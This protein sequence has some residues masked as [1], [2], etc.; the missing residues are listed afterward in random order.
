M[1]GHPARER[2]ALPALRKMARVEAEA[3]E[4]VAATTAFLT[5]KR[6]LRLTNRLITVTLDE[7]ELVAGDTIVITYSGVK[8]PATGGINTFAAQSSSYKGEA[9]QETWS[10]ATVIPSSQKLTLFWEMAPA[11]SF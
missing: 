11:L 3:Q 5:V 7:G 4:S 2:A 10:T 8:Q 6:Q 1:V 9:L